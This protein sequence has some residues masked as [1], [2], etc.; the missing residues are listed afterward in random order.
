ML[1]FGDGA[2]SVV[3]VKLGY[4]GVVSRMLVAL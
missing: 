4:M 3:G 2:L 1:A